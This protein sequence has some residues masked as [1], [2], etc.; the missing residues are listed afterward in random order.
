MAFDTMTLEVVRILGVDPGSIRAG[1]AVMNACGP[2]IHHQ[3]SG[4]IVL[5]PKASIP[6]RLQVLYADLTELIQKYQIT[7]LAIETAFFAKN[8]QSAFKLG[9]ARGIAL[10]C[11]AQNHL[12]IAEYSA[13]EVKSSICGNGRADKTQ[14][15]QMIR[16]LLKLPADFVF[17]SPDHS[18]ALGIGLT[19]HQSKKSLQKKAPL[20]I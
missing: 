4:C 19:H 18:D 14:V 13:T 3:A 7:D 15:E 12:K 10:L 9:Q 11:A 20:A 5:N 6:N 2:K 8:A 17:Q 1:F 16:I